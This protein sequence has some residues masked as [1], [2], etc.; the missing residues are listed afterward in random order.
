MKLIIFIKLT[1]FL[2]LSV[3][4]SVSEIIHAEQT[5]IVGVEDNRYFPHY[6][7]ED[8]E[9][10]GIGRQVLDTF[11]K[12][13]GYKFEY[14]ALPV[15]RLFQSFVDDEFDF[16][17][18]DNPIWSAE[19]K[20]DKKIIY[21]L[22]VMP[23][24]DGVM[25]LPENFGK[26]KFDDIKLLATIRGFTAPQWTEKRKSGDVIMGEN[27]SSKL[28]VK[29]ALAGRIQGAYANIDILKYVLREIYN[30]PKA[31][32][33]DTTL[34]YLSQDYHLSTIRH[35][36]IIKEFNEW[37]EENHQ[38]LEALKDKYGISEYPDAQP[39]EELLNEE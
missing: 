5:Y 12:S 1:C 21:S 34:P 30:Q 18:P 8:S 36:H 6:S 16:K 20:E 14:K 32:V 35:P 2:I 15:A 23:S 9:Y 39:L 31:L 38:Y 28:L 4:M 7:Y 3:C 22:P 37:V 17:Y 25:V 27:D 11:F 10:I 29:Q 13:K 19:L 33:F 24:T 26:L